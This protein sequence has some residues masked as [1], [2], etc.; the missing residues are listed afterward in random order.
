MT[1][2]S[3]APFWNW[4]AFNKIYAERFLSDEKSLLSR[5]ENEKNETVF[6]F[7][8]TKEHDKFKTTLE[9]LSNKKWWYSKTDKQIH[10][11]SFGLSL[12]DE[13]LSPSGT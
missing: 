4:N 11:I 12:V 5:S 9:F 10:A 13:V 8:G 7:S 1:Q 6:V 3:N 2:H